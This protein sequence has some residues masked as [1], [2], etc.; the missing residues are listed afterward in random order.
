MY[1]HFSNDS[2]TEFHCLYN[3]KLVNEFIILM[4]PKEYLIYDILDLVV[5]C[6]SPVHI[7]TFYIRNILLLIITLLRATYITATLLFT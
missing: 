6:F 3:S 2:A 4:C 5:S 1:F 7:S